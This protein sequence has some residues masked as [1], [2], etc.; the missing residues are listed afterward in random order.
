MPRKRTGRRRGRPQGSRQYPGDDRL[1]VEMAVL[2]LADPTMEVLAAAKLKAPEAAGPTGDATKAR[3]LVRRY[4]KHEQRWRAR[5]KRQTLRPRSSF[6]DCIESTRFLKAVVENQR[7]FQ[8]MV[9]CLERDMEARQ[10]L[11]G[12]FNVLTRYI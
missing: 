8:V 9:E 3:R 4:E 10:R 11:L 1:C 5:G 2:L 6:L 12:T 7:Q